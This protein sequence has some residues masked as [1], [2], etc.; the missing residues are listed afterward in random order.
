MSDSPIRTRNQIRAE[1]AHGCISQHTGQSNEKDYRQLARGFPA[2]V[3]T[4]GLVQAVAFV[5]A[6]EGEAGKSYLKDLS[7]VMPLAPNSDPLPQQSRMADVVE[8]QSLTR[9]AMV[10]AAWL[11]RYAEALLKEA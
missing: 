7:F 2:L 10:S 8:Y 1:K 3:H 5:Q 9:D 11:K 4:C 6:K